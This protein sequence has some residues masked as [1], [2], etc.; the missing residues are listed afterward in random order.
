MKV[1][2]VSLIIFLIDQGSKIFVRGISIPALNIY[3]KGISPDEKI[4]VINN[5]F[6]ISLIENPGIAF[7][8]DFGPDFR[9]PV[10]IITFLTG[11]GLI[12]YLYKYQ[13]TA[14]VTLRLSLAFITGGAF[15]NLVD[16]IFYGIVYDYAPVFYGRVVDFLEVSTFKLYLVSGSQVNYIFNI[17]DVAVCIGLLIFL[18][19][20][21]KQRSG[22]RTETPAFESVL[23][24][25]D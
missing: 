22:E 4:P 23:V 16:R 10:V 24:E 14:S 13:K 20:L 9:L 15:G 5:F 12:Y 17:A 6:N 2:F 19:S 11:V 8:I 18:F 1:L 3:Y 25:K 7:G 21:N